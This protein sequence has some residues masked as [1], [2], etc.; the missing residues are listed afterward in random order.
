MDIRDEKCIN[1]IKHKL[2]GGSVKKR[3]GSRTLRYR[4]Q[5]KEGMR[6]IL[7]EINGLLMHKS[8]KEEYEKI[9]RTEKYRMEKKEQ[10]GHGRESAY[11][12]G[13]IEAEGKIKIKMEKAPHAKIARPRLEIS[14]NN[15][16]EENIAMFKEIFEGKIEAENGKQRRYK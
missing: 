9:A 3:S 11:Y 14:I 16:Q 1:Y 15:K 2:G 4:L 5:E 7:K 10:R 8:R 13:R 6:E 12:A